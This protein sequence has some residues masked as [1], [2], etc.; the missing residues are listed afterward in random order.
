MASFLRSLGVWLAGL[1]A[2]AVMA[3]SPILVAVSPSAFGAEGLNEANS[4]V[5]AF[6]WLS[7][8]TLPLGA[9]AAVVWT[10]LAAVWCVRRVLERWEE[11]SVEAAAGGISAGGRGR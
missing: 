11:P 3:V 7:L 8:A 1:A 2:I 10:G 6:G 4:A 5:V 9:A